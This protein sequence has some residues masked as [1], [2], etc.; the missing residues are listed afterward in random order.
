MFPFYSCGG[1]F[2]DE[3]ARVLSAFFEC[4]GGFTGMCR[5]PVTVSCRVE[6]VGVTGSLCLARFGA[7]AAFAE[8]CFASGLATESFFTVGLATESPFT[9]G[10]AEESAFGAPACT[11][12][13]AGTWR[14]PG[15]VRAATSA[16]IA[17]GELLFRRVSEGGAEFALYKVNFDGLAEM[18]HG[19]TA[20]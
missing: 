12:S 17:R 16:G 7:G 18:F 13:P 5:V 15:R 4:I 20:D 8:S 14:A 6:S 1:L 3:S 11:T 10:F 9:S 2:A 19:G